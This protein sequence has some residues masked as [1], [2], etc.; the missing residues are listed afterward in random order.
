MGMMSTINIK[1]LQ[2]MKVFLSLLFSRKN[3]FTV[4]N[5]IRYIL[6]I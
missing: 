3:D 4:T 5:V 2:G 6:E 1:A